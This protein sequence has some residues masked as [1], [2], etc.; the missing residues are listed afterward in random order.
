MVDFVAEKC[1]KKYKYTHIIMIKVCDLA[2]SFKLYISPESSL[3]VLLATT[4]PKVP[5]GLA[6]KERH[7]A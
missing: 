4:W 2:Q 7:S 5:S 3:G 1:S 6:S